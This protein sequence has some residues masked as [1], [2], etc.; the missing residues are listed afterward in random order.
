MHPVTSLQTFPRSF[1][2]IT[3]KAG[4]STILEN[5]ETTPAKG[6]ISKSKYELFKENYHRRETEGIRNDSQI[7]H[8]DQMN[9]P[10]R[11]RSI[12]LKEKDKAKD[13]RVSYSQM[14]QQHE[15]CFKLLQGAMEVLD[16]REKK[17]YASIS[18]LLRGVKRVLEKIYTRINLED[19]EMLPVLSIV[20]YELIQLEKVQSEV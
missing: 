14:I 13:G 9:R 10:E 15:A 19:T 8:G 5:K 16:S 11:S 12:T 6:A 18:S 3:E 2:R 4:G 20:K 1:T 17:G 7:L